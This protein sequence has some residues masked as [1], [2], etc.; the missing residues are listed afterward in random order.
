MGKMT[1]PEEELAIAAMVN[2]PECKDQ[3]Y[4]RAA[5]PLIALP[6]VLRQFVVDTAHAFGIAPECIAT[7]ALAT[8]ATAIGNTCRIRLAPNWSEPSVL[9]AVTLMESGTMKTPA[10][11]AAF[12]PLRAAQRLAEEQYTR[13]VTAF[14]RSKA[15]Y[16][17]DATMYKTNPGADG[18]QGPPVEPQEPTPV[19]YYRSDATVEALGV[20]FSRNPRGL[21]MTRDELSAFF[22]SF[23]VYKGGRGGDEAAYLEFFNAGSVKLNRAGGKRIYVH[24][25]ALSIF[26]TC[27]PVVFE[28]AIG[29]LGRGA[30]QVENGLAARFLIACPEARP[31]RWIN[32][33]PVPTRFY[34]AM[35][36]QLLSIP[37][38]VDADGR[39]DPAMI[40]VQPDAQEM[41]QRFVQEH[42]VHTGS[43]T[44]PAL[45]FHY[46]KLEA[47]AAR[48]ALIF[49]LC[50][51]A[52]NELVGPPGVQLRHI[53][54]GIAVA[55]WFGREAARVYDGYDSR[56]EREKREQLEV[57][58]ELLENIRE[59]GGTITPRAMG[60]IRRRWCNPQVAEMALRALVRDGYGELGMEPACGGR[61][62][63]SFRFKL[64]DYPVADQNAETPEM[65]II[66]NE[67]GNDAAA[68]AD[69]E[70]VSSL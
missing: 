51:G 27:Q 50:D 24:A 23:G 1:G 11:N 54:G 10:Y 19:D 22:A 60:R 62:R 26:G 13:D 59:H 21:A 8:C 61:G 65:E 63:P 14:K 55:R 52:T 41:Y 12:D 39:A 56:A 38:P 67:A 7:P 5:F 16:E 58:C 25:A 49:Y 3:P 9:W 53:L 34:W 28:N 47:I 57:Q 30:N 42:G 37:L 70:D 15:Q 64:F 36:A 68:C 17:Q 31:K 4:I 44:N 32:Y 33:K 43:I 6:R 69:V 18:T 46:A 35:V 20:L 2:G 45:R 66:A 40:G 48:L 29:A